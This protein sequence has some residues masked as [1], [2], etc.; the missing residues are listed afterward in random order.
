[1][2][3]NKGQIRTL[4]PITVEDGKLNIPHLGLSLRSIIG[5]AIKHHSSLTLDHTHIVP[6]YYKAA[7]VA[8]VRLGEDFR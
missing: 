8:T 5:A 2:Q 4:E 1:M 6:V 3:Q 7:R